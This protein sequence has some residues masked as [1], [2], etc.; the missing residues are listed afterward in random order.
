MQA[1]NKSLSWTPSICGSYMYADIPP[2]KQHQY[3]IRD[4]TGGYG[5]YVALRKYPD[6]PSCISAVIYPVF[7]EAENFCKQNFA[8]IKK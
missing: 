1:K 3:Q 2:T 8:T 6:Q 7:F 4:V 5:C